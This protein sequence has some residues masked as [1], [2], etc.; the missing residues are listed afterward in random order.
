MVIVWGVAP[1]QGLLEAV[2]PVVDLSKDLPQQEG[3]Q[4]DEGPKA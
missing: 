2:I 1:E 4:K 3:L